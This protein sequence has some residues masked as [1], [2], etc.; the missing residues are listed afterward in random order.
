MGSSD[1]A[2]SERRR[3]TS[4]RVAAMKEKREQRKKKQGLEG[5]DPPTRPFQFPRARRVHLPSKVPVALVGSLGEGPGRYRSSPPGSDYPV[6]LSPPP[7]LESPSNID[8][9]LPTP[10][11]HEEDLWRNQQTPLRSSRVD[12]MA[13]PVDPSYSSSGTR[14]QTPPEP[15]HF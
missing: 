3:A 15:E 4:R 11:G 8:L 1:D 5:L 9:G 2:A 12:M 10:D 13:S 7:P 6:I 14:I